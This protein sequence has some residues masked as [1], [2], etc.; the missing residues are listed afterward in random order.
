MSDKL[1]MQVVDASNGESITRPFT[2]E[3]EETHKVIQSDESKFQEE[4]ES[5]SKAKASALAKLLK[6]GL[7]EEEIASL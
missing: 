5:K 4:I 2:S 3:E 1:V 7:T 6:L